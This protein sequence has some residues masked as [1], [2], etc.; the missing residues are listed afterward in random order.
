MADRPGHDFRYAIDNS[1]IS[2]TL[3]WQP[4]VSFEK[5]LKLTAN[6]YLD[7]LNWCDKFFKNNKNFNILS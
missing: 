1:L 2:K 4:N 5:G 6:W 3:K 7:N